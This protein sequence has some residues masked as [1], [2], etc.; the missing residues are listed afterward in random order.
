MR[1]LLILGLLVLTACP[2][3]PEEDPPPTGDTGRVQGKLSPFLGSSSLEPAARPEILKGQAAAEL[4]RALQRARTQQRLKQRQSALE[5]SQPDFPILSPPPGP[6]PL[7]RVPA[8]DPTIIGDVIVR[9]EQAGVSAQRALEQVQAPGYRVAHKGYASEY[10][11]LVGFEAVDGH[12]LTAEET[13]QLVA[14]VAQVP[15]VRFTE[16]NLRMYPTRTPNDKVY[17]AQWH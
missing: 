15:G 9:F 7:K 12:A 16:K 8:T 17:S 11:H 1:R 2:E 3:D 14:R 4:S 10:L 5:V 13:G 6:P